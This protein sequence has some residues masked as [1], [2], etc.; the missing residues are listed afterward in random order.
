M[1]TYKVAETDQ[2]M[3]RLCREEPM[4]PFT[5]LAFR[6]LSAHLDQCGIGVTR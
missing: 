5:D 2:F 4:T 1:D 6:A 3:L